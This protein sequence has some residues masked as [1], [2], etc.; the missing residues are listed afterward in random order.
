MKSV[1]PIRD[2]KTI[3]NMRA[4]LKSQSTRNELLF[5]LGINVGLRISDILKLKVRDLTKSNTKAPKDYVIITEIKTRKT[6]KFY[7][8]DIVK[9]VIENYMKENDN[10]GFD[11]Y[12]FLSRKGINMPITRQQ[13]YRIINN[14]AES[15]GIVERNDQGNLIHGE[16]GTH[17]LRKTFGYHSFQ[18]GTSLELLMDLFNH[19]SKT[20]TLRYIGIT[21]E[22]K[23]D[24]Y[25]KSNLG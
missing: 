15:L 24:V 20:Q 25:L 3:K 18:N 6:K 10:P 9:K 2:T 19:S 17:T 14:A 1:E 16:I 22:Q 23:K 12:I 5:I 4:I 8:G 21:E 13:A 11:T 7:I